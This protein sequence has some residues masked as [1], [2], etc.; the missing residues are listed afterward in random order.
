MLLC[1]HKFV[2]EAHVNLEEKIA[3]LEAIWK[4]TGNGLSIIG[5]VG[6]PSNS[7]QPK[8]TMLSHTDPGTD[9]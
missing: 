1:N 4:R 3:M 9:I 2:A 7:S 6:H 8:G 5:Q